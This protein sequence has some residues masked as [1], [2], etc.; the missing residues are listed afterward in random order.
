M[1]QRLLPIATLIGVIAWAAAYAESVSVGAAP[2]IAGT[3]DTPAKAPDVPT[4]SAS[5][6]LKLPDSKEAP[7]PSEKPKEPSPQRSEPRD[8]TLEDNPPMASPD[9]SVTDKVTDG[10]I[11]ALTAEEPNTIVLQGLNKVTGHISRLE[12]PVGTVMRFGNLE[13]IGRRC[14]KSPPDEQPENAG[15][16]EIWE[17]K[18]GESHQRIFLGWIFSS[19]PGLSGLEHPVYDLT[20]LE[21]L[22]V[23]ETPPEEKKAEEPSTQKKKK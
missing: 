17:L 22:S 21:C 14:W 23:K 1:I 11:A 10:A 9:P 8:D 18:P 16:L 13:I 3:S 2:E 5:G 20:M 15:L 19:S 7:T 12:A 6:F 4:A